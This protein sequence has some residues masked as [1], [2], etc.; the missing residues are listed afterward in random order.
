MRLALI[1]LA[2]LMTACVPVANRA[3]DLLERADG[4]SVLYLTDGV[5]FDSGASP[6]LGIILIVIG[7]DLVLTAAP[8]GAACTL[9]EDV[10]DCRLGDV[11]GRVA[12]LL[13]GQDVVASATFRRA[14]GTGVYQAFGR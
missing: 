2:L 10:I 7:D 11:D 8:E 3:A 12:V 5:G 13:T 9:V 4:A 1:A 6:A 14:G